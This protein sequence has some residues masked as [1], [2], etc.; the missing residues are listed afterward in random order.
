M[1]D[2]KAAYVKYKGNLDK[3]FE[4]VIGADVENEDRI[5]EIIYYYIE[6][7]EV[8]N[9][10]KF[11]NEPLNKRAKRLNKSK[12]EAEEAKHALEKIQVVTFIY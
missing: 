6:L 4:T 1:E 8:E 3:I 5:R 9:Y 11:S 10:P 2:I 7:G 12:K